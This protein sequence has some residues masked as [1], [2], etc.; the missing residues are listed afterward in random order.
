MK[1]LAVFMAVLLYSVTLSSQERITLLFVGDL[2]QHQA[3]IDAARVS[4]G[5]YDYSSCF[6]LI[7][8]QISQ[9]DLAIGNLEVTLGGRPY[10]G[11]PMF[12]APDEY[13]QAIKDAGFDILLTANNHCLDRGKK[14]MERTIQ[15]LDSS[16]I[17]YAGTYKNLSERR[18]RYP[19][20]INR[21][22]FRIALLN[23]T[24]GT[25]GIKA[26]SPN[27]VNYIDKNTILQDIQSAKA[28]QPDAIIACMHWGE[29]YQSLPNREQRELANWLLQQGV[30]HIIGSHPHVIQP[31]ELRTN[32]TEQH[33]IVYSLGNFI[34]NMSKA[35]T[36]GGLI[37]TLQLEKHPLPQPIRPSYTGQSQ[38]PLPDSNP[39]PFPYCRVSYC[40]YNLVWTGRPELTKEKNYILYPASF[41]TEHLSTR[42]KNNAE[43]S[44]IF[45]SF[46]A[47]LKIIPIFAPH[48]R[49][50]LTWWL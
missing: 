19:L 28:R 9:A 40:G 27:I 46:F 3:Q 4:E 23:Y 29:E 12:S 43:I 1:T 20:F 32:G 13:L 37:F 35:N 38:T 45:V 48:L 30:T 5:K 49:N 7:K 21:N 18:Q 31:M 10:R 50:A 39:L 22:G 6:S 15:L 11:Y 42:R 41:P 16:G 24:Y 34:S 36:D 26:T 47:I 33:I 8:E 25:N 17:R 14:G 44:K 2:M